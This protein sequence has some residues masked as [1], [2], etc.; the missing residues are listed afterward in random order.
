[1]GKSSL[2][3]G[4]APSSQ[5]VLSAHQSYQI[6]LIPNPRFNAFTVRAPPLPPERGRSPGKPTVHPAFKIPGEGAEH[7]SQQRILLDKPGQQIQGPGQQAD[8]KGE[9]L[10]AE[11]EKNRGAEE[12]QEKQAS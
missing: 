10:R 11:Q 4:V 7:L 5:R 12:R 1:M 2:F 8:R 3:S 6:A 9:S